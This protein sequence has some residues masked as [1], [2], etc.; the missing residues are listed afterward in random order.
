MLLKNKVLSPEREMLEDVLA[1]IHVFSCKRE[2]IRKYK[3][4]IKEDPDLQGLSK[5]RNFES[6]DAENTCLP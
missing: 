5:R 2:G 6:M 4:K 3:Q 1:I